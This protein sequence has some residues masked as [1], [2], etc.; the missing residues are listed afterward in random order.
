MVGTRPREW[1]PG[2]ELRS[3]R[4]AACISAGVLQT[5]IWSGLAGARVG[6]R[7]R[8][9]N[10]AGEVVALGV[11][12]EFVGSYVVSVVVERGGEK[13]RAVGILAREFRGWGEGEVEEIVEDEDLAVAIRAGAN[14]DGGNAALCCDACS[15][16]ARDAFEHDGD[17]S[18]IFERLSVGGKTIHC[19]YGLALNAITSHAVDGL[20]R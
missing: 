7:K 2:A 13:G 16:F 15:Q 12:G 17:G 14:A 6:G 10:F 18:G 11:A 9:L 5:I 20:R 3:S 19:V 8:R 1:L 4:Q